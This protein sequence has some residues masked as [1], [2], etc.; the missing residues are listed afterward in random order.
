MKSAHIAIS[1]LLVP[2]LGIANPIH[3]ASRPNDAPNTKNY[4]VRDIYLEGPLLRTVQLAGLF[5]DSKTFVDMP[6]SQP[7]DRVVQAFLALPPNPDR[8]QVKGFVDAYFLPPGTETF[9]VNLTDWRANPDFLTHIPDPPLRSWA[10]A[11][12]ARWN[13]LGRVQSGVRLCKGCGTSAILAQR[14]F[15]VPGG[16]FREYY[17]WDNYFIVRAL[18]LSGM[19][20]TAKDMILNM[21]DV[22]ERYGFMPNG[23][24]IYYLNRSQPPLLTQMVRK[25]MEAVPHDLKFLDR[26]LPILDREYQYWQ[27]RHTVSLTDA[28]SHGNASSLRPASLMVYRVNN[29]SPRPESYLEDYQTARKLPKAKRARFYAEV[30]AAAESGWDFSSRWFGP[31]ETLEH[32]RTSQ[33]VPVDLNAIMYRNEMDLAALHQ[34]NKEGANQNQ[35]ESQ[36]AQ[37]YLKAA[38][39]R[40]EAVNTWLWNEKAGMW[41]DWNLDYG[42][43]TENFYISNL[44]PLWSGLGMKKIQ[45][46]PGVGE[47]FLA[48]LKPELQYKGG[49]PTSNVA[50]G[51]QWDFPNAFPPLQYYAI[52]SLLNAHLPQSDSIVLEVVRKWID[53]NYCGWLH[54]GGERNGVTGATEGMMY[55]K[56]NAQSPGMAGSGGE[57]MVQNGFGWTNGV[58]LEL[59][60]Q[61]GHHLKAPIQC[62]A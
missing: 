53:S 49:I 58:V 56:Y 57:Y 33:V 41:Q 11:I 32:I 45:E 3:A 54:T 9:P 4:S 51:E 52:I 38:R 18:L 14:P 10:S 22:V 6:T 59:L 13:T 61:F 26:A 8:Q 39:E 36:E 25:Y 23:G 1:I 55:E 16:R 46:R 35:G 43:S 29:T 15:V 48:S 7:V 60:D 31:D 37:R 5:N 12:H 27:E 28:G 44:M 40:A 21:L 17:Y 47:R 62:D 50:T 34:L 19:H 2:G 42:N 30:A 20:E 24:R